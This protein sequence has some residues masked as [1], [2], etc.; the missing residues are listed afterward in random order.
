LDVYI[1]NPLNTDPKGDTLMFKVHMTNASGVAF[2]GYFLAS[3]V[4]NAINTWTHMVITY[5]AAT[6]VINIYQN[7]TAIGISGVAGTNGYVVGPSIP[8]SDPAKQPVTPYGPLK[9]PTTKAVLGTWQFQTNPSLTTSATAQSWAESYTGLLDN[10]RIYNKALS[11][12]EVS[13][14]YNLEKLG[15]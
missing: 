15:R 8:G 4:P 10:F 11:T 1:D 14:L 13:A 2:A 7:A 9:F 5:D 3:R 6:S 12:A